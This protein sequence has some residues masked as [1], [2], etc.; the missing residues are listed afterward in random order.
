MQRYMLVEQPRNS[1]MGAAEVVKLL[2]HHLR[3]VALNM[4]SMVHPSLHGHSCSDHLLNVTLVGLRAQMEHAHVHA[5]QHDV[6][7]TVSLS[8]RLI[9]VVRLTRAKVKLLLDFLRISEDAE[10]HELKG[11]LLAR[12]LALRHSATSLTDHV[13]IVLQ[14]GTLEL[15]GVELAITTVEADDTILRVELTEAAE[16]ETTKERS[17]HLSILDGRAELGVILLLE[18]SNGYTA[19]N[20]RGDV[21][22]GHLTLARHIENLLPHP[23][24]QA[25]NLGGH[26]ESLNG[27]GWGNIGYVDVANHTASH[28]LDIALDL[29][30]RRQEPHRIRHKVLALDQLR[31]SL[32]DLQVQSSDLTHVANRPNRRRGRNML[33]EHERQPPISVRE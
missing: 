7:L 30:L 25:L 28:I 29:V 20:A 16:C 13:R 24:Q 9:L 27:L 33:V 26:R 19:S 32:V 1:R 18:V 14:V 8:N 31:G 10:R 17:R 12:S 6:V 4:H 21:A 11:V 23:R 5:V 15:H 22:A 3:R 2:I